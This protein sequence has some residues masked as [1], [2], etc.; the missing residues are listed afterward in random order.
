MPELFLELFSEEIPAR[1]QARAAEDLAPAVRRGA[2]RSVAR[3]VREPGSWPAP[4]RAARPRWRRRSP[5]ASTTERGPRASAPEQA[6]AGFLRKHG[7]SRGAAA[8][9]RRLLGAG[10]GGTR[11]DR[12]RDPDRRAPCRRC[13]AASP[14]RNRCAGA[15]PAI[16]SGC[17][18][19]GA[20]S[21][22]WTARWCRSTCATAPMTGMGLHRDNLTEGHR[23]HAPGAFAVASA[24]DWAAKLRAA[25]RAGRRRRTQARSSRTGSPASPQSGRSRWS[26]IP[27]CWTRW[28]D[29]S[30]GRCRCS[31]ASTR[32]TWTCRRRSGRSPCG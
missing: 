29:W 21:A 1:M 10:E 2:G 11:R 19:C 5:P 31:A 30:N 17:A 6:L 22:C 32:P 24:D 3:P 20:S 28:P 9:G 27:A 4:H 25:A 13:C 26:T 8:P 7:A 12:R 18:R 14:G 23:F 16:S 15:A